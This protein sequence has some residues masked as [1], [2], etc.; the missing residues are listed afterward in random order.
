MIATAAPNGALRLGDRPVSPAALFGR[1]HF[2][3]G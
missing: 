3:A 1:L 2:P